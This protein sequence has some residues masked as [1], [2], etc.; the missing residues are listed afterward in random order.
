MKIL[1]ELPLLAIISLPIIYLGIIWN[2]LPEQVPMHWNINGE[3]DRYGNKVEL[4]LIAILLPF[5][6]YAIFLV[7]PKIDPKKKLGGMG[8]KLNKL[9][10]ILTLFMSLIAI[11]LIHSVK[12]QSLTNPSYVIMSIGVLYILFGN[13]SKTLKPNYFIGIRTPWTLENEKVWQATHKLSGLI[14]FIGG[15][16]VVI[17]SLIFEGRLNLIIFLIVT[18]VIALVPILYSYFEY[19]KQQKLNS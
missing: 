8:N 9:K 4:F 11:Y 2:Q 3:I 1:K 19:K 14:W 17:T 5:V 18:A 16:I 7:A 12:I 10:T 15:V 6:T 13:Y